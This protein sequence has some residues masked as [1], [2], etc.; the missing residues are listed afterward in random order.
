MKTIHHFITLK[1]KKLT[2]TTVFLLITAFLKAQEVASKEEVH[3]NE[4]HPLISLALFS[5]LVGVAIFVFFHYKKKDMAKEKEDNEK[6]MKL[7]AN[8]RAKNARSG[9]SSK[10]PRYNN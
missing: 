1:G 9:Y 8:L 5:L 3:S 2:G 7:R 10:Q 4:T 6:L